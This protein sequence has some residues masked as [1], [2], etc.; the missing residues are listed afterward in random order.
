MAARAS[1]LQ[2]AVVGL[3]GFIG[4]VGRYVLQTAVTIDEKHFT[5]LLINVSGSF[6]IGCLWT[7]LSAVDADSR[8]SAFLVTGVLGGYTTYSSF[9]LDF[10]RL[11]QQGRWGDAGIYAG[12]TTVCAIAACM[13]GVFITGRI[14]KLLQ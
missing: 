5:T 3:G 2:F 14:L 6:I 11:T 1:L 7:I 4:A 12:L 9:S 10:V 8:W 13:L